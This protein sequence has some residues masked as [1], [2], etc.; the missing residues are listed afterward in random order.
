MKSAMHTALE[1]L[2]YQTR[3]RSA[4]LLSYVPSG[5]PHVND[6]VGRFLFSLWDIRY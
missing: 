2:P 1:T 5:R 3:R 6:A 4:G